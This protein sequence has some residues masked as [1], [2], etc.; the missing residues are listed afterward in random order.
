MLPVEKS[1][2]RETTMWT[3]M[4]PQSAGLVRNAAHPESPGYTG[5]FDGHY[6]VEDA[7]GNEIPG[8]EENYGE[9]DQ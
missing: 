2:M 7:D 3:T 6:D 5:V 9:A 8:R 1:S 4:A